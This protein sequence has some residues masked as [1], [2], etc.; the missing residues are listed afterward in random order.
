MDSNDF[1]SVPRSGKAADFVY[2]VSLFEEPEVELCG[3]WFIV[4]YASCLGMHRADAS[5]LEISDA[6]ISTTLL[7]GQTYDTRNKKQFHV[8]CNSRGV[9]IMYLKIEDQSVNASSP[10]SAQNRKQHDNGLRPYR[11]SFVSRAA[12]LLTSSRK[13]AQLQVSYNITIPLF[14]TTHY[15]QWLYWFFSLSLSSF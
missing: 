11:S 6:A 5:S 2:R 1:T 13:E 7:L 8:N 9:S 3:K 4:R 10:L 15:Q 12:L 14:V